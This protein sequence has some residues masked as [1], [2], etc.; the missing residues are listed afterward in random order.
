LYACGFRI[1]FTPLPGFFS[2]FP[3]GTSSL[4][5]DYEYLALEDGPP[6]FRQ[7]FTCPALLVARLVL[8]SIFPIRGY[9]PLW[10]DFPDRSDKPNAKTCRL[11]RFRSPLLSESRLMSIPRA[12]E[13]FQFARFASGSYEF[14]ARYPCGWVSPF[15]NLRIKAHLPAPRSLSQAIASFIACN[16]QGIHHMHL[17]T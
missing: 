17:V 9:H 16:R 5:V 4:S 12:T 3:H 1:Y 2:P 13:M 15:G 7:D 6:I 8:H 10:P 14:R 11:F